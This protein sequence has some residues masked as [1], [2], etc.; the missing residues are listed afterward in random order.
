MSIL[1]RDIDNLEQVIDNDTI[2]LNDGKLSVSALNE[3][4]FN[5]ATLDDAT[6]NSSTI[7]SSTLDNPTLT[8][9]AVAPT[10]SAG[11]DSTKIATTAFVQNMRPVFIR[12]TSATHNLA[13]SNRTT[14]ITYN[15]ADFTHGNSDF[16]PSK[17]IGIVI[18][19]FVRS[20]QNTNEINVTLP[21][22]GTRIARTSAFGGGDDVEDITTTYIPINEG[23]SSFTINYVVGYQSNTFNFIEIK[24]VVY[25]PQL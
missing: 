11:D 5:K 6:I 19:A 22:G 2:K 4:T 10:P 20:N 3:P 12:P 18:E 8:G 15:I 17:I 16:N 24:G 21:V 9:N 14:S 13:Q 23:Q 7:N 25:L 1:I